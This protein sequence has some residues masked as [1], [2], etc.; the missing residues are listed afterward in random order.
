MRKQNSIAYQYYILIPSV[1]KQLRG[2]RV[3]SP[4]MVGIDSI[5]YTTPN[6]NAPSS[7]SS[8]IKHIP[9]IIKLD[10]LEF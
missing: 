3:E 2:G 7:N 4:D 9:P 10:K 5:P 8:E 1:P 6:K